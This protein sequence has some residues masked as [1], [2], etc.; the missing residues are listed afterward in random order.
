MLQWIV[1]VPQG[2][3]VLLFFNYVIYSQDASTNPSYDRFEVYV[4]NTLQFSDGNMITTGLNC[5]WF[6]VPGIENPRNGQI[7]GWATGM[8]D[9]NPYRGT[10]VTVSFR[11]YNRLDGW[12]NTY[13]YLDNV[14]IETP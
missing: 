9:L 13:T 8:I 12:Y 1:R 2:R 14:H 4:N 11:N 6:R 7:N 10:T 5:R 3:N